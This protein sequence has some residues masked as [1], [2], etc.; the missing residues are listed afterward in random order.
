MLYLYNDDV[1]L[2][3]GTDT[4]HEVKEFLKIGDEDVIKEHL[5][6]LYFVYYRKSPYASMPIEDRKSF[7]ITHYNLFDIRKHS[8]NSLVKEIEGNEYFEG[9]LQVYKTVNYTDLE[10]Q[11]MVY[12]SK[13]SFYLQELSKTQIDEE[14]GLVSLDP[15]REIA[16]SKAIA[17]FRKEKTEIQSLIAQQKDD[18]FYDGRLHLFEVPDEHLMPNEYPFGSF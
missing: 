10:I 14:S 18:E 4:L 1:W 7:V 2:M 17:I 3:R 11:Y 15:D 13:I 9:I 12:E 5:K 8:L 6:Y 16:I